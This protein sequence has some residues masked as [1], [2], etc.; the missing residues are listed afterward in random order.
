MV[1]G[2]ALVCVILT[3]SRWLRYRNIKRVIL[4]MFVMIIRWHLM[5]SSIALYLT[6]GYLL[7][8]YEVIP[9][10]LLAVALYLCVQ[11]HGVGYSSKPAWGAFCNIWRFSHFWQHSKTSV[12]TYLQASRLFVEWQDD[13][14]VVLKW[15]PCSQVGFT[16]EREVLHLK[17]TGY[18]VAFVQ[19]FHRLKL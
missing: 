11:L 8:V 4:W 13:C 10:V 18:P 2:A 12:I 5:V 16:W 1:V 6:V 15:M 9:M 3:T 7:S 19:H 14:I 17:E